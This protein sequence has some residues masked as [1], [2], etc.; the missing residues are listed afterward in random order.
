MHIK[1]YNHSVIFAFDI[2]LFF[3]RNRVTAESRV[4]QIHLMTQK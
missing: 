4:V 1:N 3:S 2:L